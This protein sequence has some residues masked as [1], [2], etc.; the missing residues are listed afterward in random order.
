MDSWRLK[1][2]EEW[3][4]RGFLP[5]SLFSHEPVAQEE[6]FF[7][8]G[9]DKYAKTLCHKKQKYE[10]FKAENTKNRQND[11]SPFTS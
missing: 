1:K 10:N 5:F 8:V 11:D 4:N 7:W 9:Q 3:W 2:T 6:I